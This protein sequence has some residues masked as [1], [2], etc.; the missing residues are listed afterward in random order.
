VQQPAKPVTPSHI[1]R[2]TH[3][4][5][6]D[7]LPTVRWD[8]TE[9]SASCAKTPP[10]TESVGKPLF[11][12]LASAFGRRTG[13]KPASTIVN[14]AQLAPGQRLAHASAV[15][16][17]PPPLAFVVL[18]FAGWVNRQQQAVIDFLLEENR[19]LR[20]AHGSRRVRLTD[21]QRRRLAVKGKVLGRRR[22]AAIAGIVTPDTILR[23]YRTLVAKKYDGSHARRPGRPRTKADLVALVVRMAQEN[24]TWGYS[25]ILGGLKG[26]GH[27]V[28]RSTIKAILKEHGIEPAPERGAKMPWKAFLSAHWDALAAADFFTVEV[29]TLRGLVPY[30]VFFVMKL[31]TRRVAIAGISRQPDETWMTQIARNLT[32]TGDGF[33]SGMQQV[34]LDRDPLYTVGFRRLLRDSG[35]TPVVLPA[36]SPNLNAFAERFV[37]SVKSECSDRLVLLGERHLRAAVAE[38]VHHYHEERPHQG[39]G[40]ALIAPETTMTGTG[41]VKCR[42]RLGGLLKFYYR[43]AA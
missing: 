42:Q 28:G 40:N 10:T 23:W 38:F 17:L 26:L 12:Q 18:L 15:D 25:R 22:L 39:L 27:E 11:A 13:A 21:D 2:L 7:G 16:S 4:F 41:Q 29:L 9:A 35:V 31:K 32:A 30:V 36:R 5:G 37:E 19:V 33:L 1:D 3:R 43:E 34:I 14:R 6:L 24:P 20:A 8:Q